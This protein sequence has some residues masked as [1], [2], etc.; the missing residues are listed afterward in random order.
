MLDECHARILQIHHQQIEN[1]LQDYVFPT[2]R[3]ASSR[4]V[5]FR[6][7]IAML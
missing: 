7:Q 3:R 6:L 5:L 4:Y 2:H 1:A